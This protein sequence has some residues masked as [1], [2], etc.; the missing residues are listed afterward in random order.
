LLA[1]VGVAASG[2]VAAWQRI[3]TV[4]DLFGTG[5]G[6]LVALKTVAL[7]GLGVFGALHRKRL[8]PRIA[9]EARGGKV[10]AWFVLAELAV[11]GVA[12]GLAAALGRTATPVSF[13]PARDRGG[14]LPPSEI[15]TG[16]PMPPE[17][18]AT[19]YITEWKFDI[20]WTLVVVFGIAFYLLGV[21]RLSKRGDTWPIGRT[22]SWLFGLVMLFYT[23]NGALNAYEQYV[24][25]VHMLGHMMLTM[26]IPLLLVL[27][28]P[29]TLTMR[30]VQKR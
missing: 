13:E 25:S 22:L 23:T 3:G 17:L 19:S 27:G 26:L 2:V 21:M 5:Y 9:G 14:Y 18:T 16:D 12:S 8:I 7:V 20:A 30:A 29:V 15:L 28:A 11:M 1:F 4:E 10:F 6:M 24:F